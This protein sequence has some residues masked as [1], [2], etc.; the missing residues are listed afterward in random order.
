MS[1]RSTT[2]A[3]SCCSRVPF[4]AP[5]EPSRLCERRCRSVADR[6]TA[7]LYSADGTRTGDGD[8]NPD[9]FGIEPNMAVMYQV[10]NAQRAAARA[11]THSTKT[12]AEVSGGGR[13]PWRQKGLGRA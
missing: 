2:S 8:L 5:R 13:K 6:L 12:R 11:G 1:S 10:V 7:E 4:P 9:T 3:T